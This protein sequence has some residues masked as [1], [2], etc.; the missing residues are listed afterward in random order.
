[1]EEKFQQAV[2]MK[3][4]RFGTPVFR[5]QPGFRGLGGE[6]SCEEWD[7]AVQAKPL[8]TTH[9]VDSGTVESLL[10]EIREDPPLLPHM[11]ATAPDGTIIVESEGT[12]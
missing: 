9:A 4:K 5:H 6:M 8:D 7:M 11:P 2:E 10:L 3:K 12:T 1:M